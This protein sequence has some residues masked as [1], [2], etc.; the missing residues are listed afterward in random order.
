LADTLDTFFDWQ[1]ATEAALAMDENRYRAPHSP[2]LISDRAP[3]PPTKRDR[4]HIFYIIVFAYGTVQSALSFSETRSLET[5]FMTVLSATLL[6]SSAL[7]L[8]APRMKSTVERVL[9]PLC[10]TW[11]VVYCIL[12]FVF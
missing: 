12:K 6:A 1:P 7:V 9:M 11:V 5:L 10:L 8:A 4:W 2:T 3:A